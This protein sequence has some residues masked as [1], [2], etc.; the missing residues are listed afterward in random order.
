MAR[1]THLKGPAIDTDDRCPH[2]LLIDHNQEIL[3]LL[4]ELLED[5][6]FQVAVSRET[7]DLPRLRSLLPEV[8]VDEILVG[9]RPEA[10]WQ[11]L[12]L[13]QRAPERADVSL[14]LCTTAAATMREPAVA[15]SLDRLGVRVLCQP[16]LIGDLLELVARTLSGMPVIG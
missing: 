13:T 12:T 11:F 2:V 5:D 1:R 6:G 7:S 3:D 10:G 4:R 8:I 9:G 15:E 16:F 14:V